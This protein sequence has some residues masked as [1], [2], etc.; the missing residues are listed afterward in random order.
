MKK[1]RKD[2]Q[3]K[4]LVDAPSESNVKTAGKKKYLFKMYYILLVDDHMIK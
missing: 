2:V 3:K 4:K 1:K